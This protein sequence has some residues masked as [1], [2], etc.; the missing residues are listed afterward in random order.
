M[1]Q[2]HNF[3]F[4]AD[5]AAREVSGAAKQVA[6][7][8]GEAVAVAQW[9]LMNWVQRPARSKPHAKWRLTVRLKKLVD[10]SANGSAHNFRAK[11][12]ISCFTTR[13]CATKFVRIRLLT[14]QRRN[15]DTNLG[16]CG[17]HIDLPP[18]N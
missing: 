13:S 12:G 16:D 14:A 2:A 9:L 6:L 7:A 5:A 8:A 11:S 10:L 3:A 15:G 18:K 1:T 4:V 17:T